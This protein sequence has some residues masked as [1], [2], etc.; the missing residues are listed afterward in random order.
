MS[1]PAIRVAN[2]SKNFEVYDSPREIAL[3]ILSRKKRH[4]I[5]KALDDVSFDV[6]KGE[7]LGIIGS[8]GAGKSTLLKIITGD[9]DPTDGSVEIRGKVTAIL[10]LGLGFNMEYTGREN[11]KLSGLLYGMTQAEIDRKLDAIIDFSGLGDFIEM[12]IKTYSSGMFAR[13]AFSIATAADPEILIIDE[14]LA[15]GDAM[16]VQKCLRRIREFCNSGRTVLLVSHGTGLLAQLCKRV[17]WL[18]KGKLKACGP[19]LSVIQQYDMAAHAGVDSQSW[20]EDESS[21]KLPTAVAGTGAAAEIAQHEPTSN[22]EDLAAS[23]SA[24]VA[25]VGPAAPPEG[26]TKK[27]LKRGPYFIESVELLDASGTP[28]STITTTLPFSLRVKYRCEGPIPAGTLGIAI[29]VNRQHD[30][31]P[32]SQ[33]FTQN[34]MPNETRETYNDTSARIRPS[35]SRDHCHGFPVHALQ[36]RC[37]YP[38]HRFARQRTRKLGVLRVSPSVLSIQR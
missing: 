27:I 10:E 21:A 20:L 23:A 17:V 28:S 13:L 1:A 30:L 14:A 22:S 26:E 31:A 35:H 4:R 16:F 11:I 9:L 25:D 15:A 37:V 29:A 8:N 19:A 36:R 12:P 34:I 32:V 24:T 18:D 33:W 7:V 5:F 2:L 3:E 6:E 38:I